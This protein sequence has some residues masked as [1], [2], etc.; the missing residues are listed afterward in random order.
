MDRV[1]GGDIIGG[2]E[3]QLLPGCPPAGY[4]GTVVGREVHLEENRSE[5]DHKYTRTQEHKYPRIHKY[6]RTQVHKSI[7]TLQG[8]FFDWHSLNL[9]KSKLPLKLAQNFSMCQRL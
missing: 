4:H 9:A 3:P 6:R 2:V 7:N 8:V 5:T 1:Y